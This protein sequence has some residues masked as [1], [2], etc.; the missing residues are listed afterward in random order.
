M[1]KA[2]FFDVDGT[3]LSHKQKKIPESTLYALQQLKEHHIYKV[4]ATGRHYVELQDLPIDLSLFD[5]YI[6]LNG[7]LCL[8]Q[9]LNIFKA[10]PIVENDK[11]IL[12]NLFYQKRLPVML[13]EKD[14]MYINFINNDVKI[15]QEA[16]STALPDVSQYYGDEIYQAIVYGNDNIYSL[17]N[18]LK[19]SKITRWNDFA[20]D[21]I[22]NNGGKSLG[23][24]SYLELMHMDKEEAMAFGDGENDLDMLMYVDYG[25]A[26]GNAC[27]HVKMQAFDITT[28]I[29]DDGIYNALLKYHLL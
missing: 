5:A 8:T 20:V 17:L 3:L 11:N 26:M 12:L 13:I 24:Q 18:D 15:A 21:I 22:S 6:T 9:D 19:F 28:S 2:I 23:I 16:I 14:R 7:Q 25:I 27:E 1:I 4:L 29:D 10:N